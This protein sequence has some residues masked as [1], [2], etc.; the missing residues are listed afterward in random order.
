M[1]RI[2]KRIA[3]A[4]TAAALVAGLA[5]PAGALDQIGRAHV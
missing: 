2:K 4:L 5:I 3:A 1:N